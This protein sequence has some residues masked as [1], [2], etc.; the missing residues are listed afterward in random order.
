LVSGKENNTIWHNIE[1]L[2]SSSVCETITPNGMNVS[3]DELSELTYELVF[4]N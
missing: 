4:K 3:D 2:P 1:L